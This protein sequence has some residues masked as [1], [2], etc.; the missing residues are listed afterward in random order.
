M[1]LRSRAIQPK[2]ARLA[3]VGTRSPTALSPRVFADLLTSS[4]LRGTCSTLASTRDEQLAD[5]LVAV[6][7]KSRSVDFEAGLRGRKR[8]KL[9]DEADR[10]ESAIEGLEQLKQRFSDAKRC[11][12]RRFSALAPSELTLLDSA[13]SSN[14]TS[15]S[16]PFR[17]ALLRPLEQTPH[18]KQLPQRRP[19]LCRA[20]ML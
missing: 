6:Q 3:C 10:G 5:L 15:P 9:A 7:D 18:D 19:S 4:R 20:A 11:I 14:S 16:L 12:P 13:A 1:T 8:R 17:Q 2:E